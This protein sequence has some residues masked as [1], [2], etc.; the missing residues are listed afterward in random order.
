MYCPPTFLGVGI[1]CA[2]AHGNHWMIRAIIVK[3]SQ[4]I[5][6]K[7]IKIVVTRCQILRLK[8]TKFNFDWGSAPDPA[9][10]AY[11]IPTYHLARF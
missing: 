11:S 3:S 9:Q 1:F 6:M 4:L 10:A 5:L 7:I 2:N 8:G